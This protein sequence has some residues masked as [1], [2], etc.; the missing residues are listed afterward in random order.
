MFVKKM[1]PARLEAVAG[2]LSLNLTHTI[3]YSCCPKIPSKH[4]PLKA[5]TDSSVQINS[6]RVYNA[7]QQDATKTKDD[8]SNPEELVQK[9]LS[10]FI[11]VMEDIS[12]QQSANSVFDISCARYLVQ[13]TTFTQLTE[14]VQCLQHCDLTL[15]R[16]NEEKLCFFINLT[17]LML[18][19][20]HLFNVKARYEVICNIC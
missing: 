12:R 3:V 4:P 11:S 1:A 14:A 13:Q 8:V 10:D 15:L 9:L 17:N 7:S 5:V 18:I 19:H 2:K 20:C 6:S 16:C